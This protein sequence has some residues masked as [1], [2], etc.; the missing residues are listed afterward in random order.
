MSWSQRL[1]EP[2]PVGPLPYRWYP[3]GTGHH[4]GKPEPG[5]V[6]ALWHA[7]WRVVSATDRPRE[8]WDPEDEELQ[9]ELEQPPADRCEDV[10]RAIRG[11]FVP[12]YAVVLRPAHITGDDPRSRDRDVS[13]AAGG[14]R[15]NTWDVYRHEHY[16]V[17]ARCAEP[18]P[19]R[20]QMA[21]R[22][23]AA[24]AKKLSRY[25]LAGVCPACE[26]PVTARQRSLTWPENLEVPGGPPVTFHDRSGCRNSA[27]D[28]EERWVAADPQRRAPTLTCTGH[29]TNHADGTYNC[30]EDAACPGPRARHR[31]YSVCS[32]PDCHARPV[33]WGCTPLP[34]ALRVAPGEPAPPGFKAPKPRTAPRREQPTIPVT[35]DDH[36]QLAFPTDTP[37]LV[38]IG[39]RYPRLLHLPSG[40]LVTRHGDLVSLKAA[41][42]VAADLRNIGWERDTE[43]LRADTT[44]AAAVRAA[45]QATRDRR[46]A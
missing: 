28:Y 12:P 19:C 13:V 4:Y 7:A 43:A 23:S 40:L 15:P 1:P 29:V 36:T 6:V 41:R 21:E 39:Q 11:P 33:R 27:A 26:E 10:L 32:C 45:I 20:E 22:L 35:H 25:E 5:M 18:L 31:G 42:E 37:G 8:L 44:I 2:P 9:R 14:R 30:T 17:C 16:A 24:A 34:G 3:Q 38:V 46:A